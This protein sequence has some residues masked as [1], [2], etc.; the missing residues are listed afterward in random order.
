MIDKRQ[1]TLS[2]A[3]V[4]ALLLSTSSAALAKPNVI[5]RA[6]QQKF[7]AAYEGECDSFL[8]GDQGRITPEIFKLSFRHDYNNAPLTVYRLYKFP[9]YQG[10]YNES[11]VFYGADDY[12]QILQIHFAFPQFEVTYK[13]EQNEILD[14]ISQTG[15]S[16]HHTLTN[17]SFDETTQTL[18][19]R[20]AWRG[21]GDAS[22]AGEWLFVRG[23]F[24]LQNYEI[25]PTYD[26]EINPIRIYGQSIGT[27][28]FVNE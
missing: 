9:C 14:Q 15:F 1:T 28:V 6:V 10:A 12:D 5:D 19:S 24:I 2:A 11:S 7:E 20:S 13:D 17:S 27:P 18:H 26:G 3:L 4:G 16:T 25:D 23:K 21:L 22:S 8:A